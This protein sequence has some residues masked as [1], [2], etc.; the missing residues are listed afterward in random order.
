M[1]AVTSS[2]PAPP[3]YCT[4][5]RAPLSAEGFAATPTVVCSSCGTKMTATLFPAFTTA[6]ITSR[7]AETLVV[8]GEASCF[9]HAG[10]KA[11]VACAGCGRFLCGLC[12]LPWGKDHL[13]STCL[14]AWKRKGKMTELENKRVLYDHVAF[15]VSI[16]PLLLFFF[17]FPLFCTIAT[18]PLAIILSLRYWSAPNSL[19]W[20][21]APRFLLAIFLSLAQIGGWVWLVALIV[22]KM[23]T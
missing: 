13:C 2:P 6:T 15:W 7:A 22:H 14:A 20:S 3:L 18:A 5:C 8:D 19:V 1:E 12:D 11:V 23:K 17:V 9:F 16:G 10:K 21:K 4:K